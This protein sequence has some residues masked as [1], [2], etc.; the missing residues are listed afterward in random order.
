MH[1]YVVLF[2]VLF[3]CSREFTECTDFLIF[4]EPE[5]VYTNLELFPP[6]QIWNVEGAT[7]YVTEQ[8]QPNEFNRS[9]DIFIN[10]ST[11]QFI[12][13]A[14]TIS[15][16]NGELFIVLASVEQYEFILSK[17]PQLYVISKQNVIGFDFDVFIWK[18]FPII[19]GL[20][21]MDDNNIHQFQKTH[22]RELGADE[23]CVSTNLVL[24]S[25]FC[26]GD[27]SITV[28]ETLSL[29]DQNVSITA[30]NIYIHALNIN[31]VSNFDFTI[32]CSGNVTIISDSM[33]IFDTNESSITSISTKL[34]APSNINLTSPNFRGNH[35]LI[36]TNSAIEINSGQLGYIDI[37]LEAIF[38]SVKVNSTIV[39]AGGVHTNS[40]IIMGHGVSVSQVQTITSIDKMEILSTGNG[41]EYLD[42]FV[43][44]ANLTICSQ[45]T[46]QSAIVIDGTY[47]GDANFFNGSST[48]K[49]GVKLNCKASRNCENRN[50]RIFG[51]SDTTDSLKS[52]IFVI[53]TGEIDGIELD[54]KATSNGIGILVH[55]NSNAGLQNVNFIGF[56]EM[57]DYGIF[58]QGNSGQ[59]I[60]GTISGKGNLY[61]VFL[62][63]FSNEVGILDIEGEA[64]DISNS[65]GV[66]ISMLQPSFT[67]NSVLQISGKGSTG[68]VLSSNVNQIIQSLDIIGLS[69][70]SSGTG[71]GVLLELEMTVNTCYI[72]GN[73]T[74]FDNI[75]VSFVNPLFSLS[76]NGNQLI[77]SSNSFIYLQDVTSRYTISGIAPFLK[78]DGFLKIDDNFEINGKFNGPNLFFSRGVINGNLTIDISGTV[79]I[80]NGLQINQIFSAGINSQ[81]YVCGDIIA[82]RIE[83]L[84]DI[85]LKCIDYY[86][87]LNMIANDTISVINVKGRLEDNNHQL[88][89]E[90]PKIF[91]SG[92]V[93]KL[94]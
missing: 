31:F 15:I 32:D 81:F 79:T 40:F 55:D 35:L 43:S 48:E 10:G 29:D 12:F 66:F 20:T 17:L 65:V 57:G 14:F 62:S 24:Q 67:I 52:A 26:D 61:G 72:E 37:T 25:C 89:I 80:E 19:V 63:G 42:S 30:D 92:T 74:N 23:C 45:A 21:I 8:I 27:M 34:Q 2:I 87:P 91:I 6:L 9:L 47:L 73:V 58:I 83:I 68:V 71:T 82:T 86:S 41:V 60:N 56:S 4:T 16:D 38:A 78:F 77:I 18:N 75:G 49:Y 1:L 3:N 22:T 46:S 53:L 28:S 94:S 70:T 64:N 69:L 13:S 36:S 54:G 33:I 44:T 59:Q 90:A 50:I 85:T 5:T 51:A 76:S 88:K 11:F 84:S 39:G 93:S 7:N